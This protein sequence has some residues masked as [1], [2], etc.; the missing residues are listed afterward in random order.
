MASRW[1]YGGASRKANRRN[2]AM[3]KYGSR[4]RVENDAA[5]ALSD[6]QQ[7]PKSI[8]S[9]KVYKRTNKHKQENET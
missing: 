7:R 5:K 2:A 8:P 3:H 4:I 6:P 1:A 9:G